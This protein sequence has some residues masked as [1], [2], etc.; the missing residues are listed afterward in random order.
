MERIRYMVIL[1]GILF[2]VGCANTPMHFSKRAIHRG[3]NL[4]ILP[5][6]DFTTNNNS[7]DLITDV[8]TV[9]FLE[10]GF[11]VAERERINTIISEKKLGLSGLTADSAK[12][13]GSLLNVDYLLTGSLIEYESF[14]NKKQLFYI[15][16]WL[17]ITCSLGVT[18]RLIDVQTGEIIW[19]GVATEKATSFKDAAD[20]VVGMLMETIQIER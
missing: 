8:F 10:N 4:A 5:F 15:F 13:M 1:F 2:T 11:N 14:A 7:G 12:E 9:Y 17:E 16:E 6:A 18:A 19:V 3:T 20:D